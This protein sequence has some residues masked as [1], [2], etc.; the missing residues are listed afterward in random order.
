MKN[1]ITKQ[2][3][4]PVKDKKEGNLYDKILKENIQAAVP[5]IA[6]VL[7]GFDIEKT[8][9][10]KDKMQITVEREGD[11][12]E[13]L[14]YKDKTK[15]SVLHLE[16]QSDLNEDPIK[17]M[18][19]YYGMA[20]YNYSLPVN[21]FVIYIG[22]K[23]MP[24][25]ETHFSHKNVSFKYT[26]IDIRQ[27]KAELFLNAEK[28]EV[29]ILAVLADFGVVPPEDILKSILEKIKNITN[30]EVRLKKFV[31]QLQVLS[32]LRN[33][34][35]LLNKIKD[36]MPLTIDYTEDIYYQTGKLE[37]IE[38]GQLQKD[39]KFVTNLLK[40]GTFSPEEIAKLAD[41]SVEFVLKMKKELN[42]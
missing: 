27:F 36:I 35:P 24:K 42:L 21:Q 11:F 31:R 37:G 33:L 4:A 22:N 30:S 39:K 38:L 10:I 23:P 5:F 3:T 16:F 2:T 9:T 41:V 28:P 29:I 15:D 25:Y 17:R 19:L 7:L 34:Q 6:R 13:K 12:L 14:L 8:E 18:M 26:L 32:M 1:K 40:A 20:F